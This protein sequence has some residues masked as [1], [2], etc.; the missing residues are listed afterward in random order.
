[1]KRDPGIGSQEG[2]GLSG[3]QLILLRFQFPVPGW[4]SPKRSRF[5]GRFKIRPNRFISSPVNKKTE[6]SFGPYGAA[7]APLDNLARQRLFYTTSV[8][9]V[10]FSPKTTPG[11]VHHPIPRPPMPIH[12]NL[13]ISFSRRDGSLPFLLT[14]QG[15]ASYMY[16]LKSVSCAKLEKPISG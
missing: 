12:A 15:I 8:G 14:H 9:G 2:G 3:P 11:P 1:M 16:L 6:A 7:S 10:T 13:T 4:S 5:R